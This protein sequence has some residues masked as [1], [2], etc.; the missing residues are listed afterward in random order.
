MDYS[1]PAVAEWRKVPKYVS[2]NKSQPNR[3]CPCCGIQYLPLPGSSS[4]SCGGSERVE[5]E[6]RLSGIC[7][8]T[9]FRRAKDAFDCTFGRSVECAVGNMDASVAATRAADGS[10]S[11]YKYGSGK[12][13]TEKSATTVS[14][15]GT[16]AQTSLQACGRCSIGSSGDGRLSLC[17]ACH[18]VVYCSLKCQREDWPL[19]RA[20]CRSGRRILETLSEFKPAAN[21]SSRDGHC[22]EQ[23]PIDTTTAAPTLLPLP[24]HT[25]GSAC[26]VS[27]LVSRPDLNGCIAVVLSTAPT[28]AAFE[29]LPAI[30]YGTSAATEKP[31]FPALERLPVVVYGTAAAAEKLLL[32]PA[33]LMLLPCTARSLDWSIDVVTDRCGGRAAARQKPAV[34]R[35]VALLSLVAD[36]PTGNLDTC[37]EFMDALQLSLR[38]PA[39]GP[40]PPARLFSRA[41]IRAIIRAPSHEVFWMP[42]DAIGHYFVLEVQPGGHG[43]LFQSSVRSPMTLS[44][45]VSTTVGYSPREWTNPLAR[46]GWDA[47]LKAA[48]NRW[49]GGRVLSSAELAALLGMIADLQDAGDAVVAALLP[50]LDTDLVRADEA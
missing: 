24:T 18:G 4:A 22:E 13:D 1:D 49:G 20:A 2:Y 12:G 47:Q 27:G 40:L 10:V 41:A 14:E 19:H 44:N 16:V 3:V 8:I 7:S 6:R 39:S 17:S 29:G 11:V 50:Q 38:P 34:T 28:V 46:P 9:C 33:N 31:T 26:V 25:A 5:A 48:H 45:G 15:G 42:F 21:P 37:H 43:R 36:T 30:V 32:K 23:A 35:S